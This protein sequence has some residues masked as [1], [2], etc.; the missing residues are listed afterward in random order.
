MDWIVIFSVAIAFF[1]GYAIVSSI[2]GKLNW[3]NRNNDQRERD[4]QRHSEENRAG[5][6]FKRGEL[7][8]NEE[9]HARVLGIQADTSIANIKR[10]YREQLA[11]YHPDKVNHLGT[12]FQQIAAD[13]TRQIISAYEYFRKKYYIT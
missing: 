12:E 9:A 2:A 1:L 7:Q 5:A 6:D 4:N 8:H 13:R 10:A 3:S 11:R